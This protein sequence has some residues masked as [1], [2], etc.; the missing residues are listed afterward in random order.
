MSVNVVSDSYIAALRVVVVVV[1]LL[2]LCIV[3]KSLA[4]CVSE[5][6]INI[7]PNVTQ[8]TNSTPWSHF[9]G[10]SVAQYYAQWCLVQVS[11]PM[12]TLVCVYSQMPHRPS[13]LLSH[14]RCQDCVKR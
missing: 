5:L 9:R 7:F 13:T 3:Q 1:L 8:V 2:Y 4:V 6:P 12:Q 14:L 11:A 10:S